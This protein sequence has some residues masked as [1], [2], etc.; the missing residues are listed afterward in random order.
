MVKE[1]YIIGIIK[2]LSKNRIEFEVTYNRPSYL[3]KRDTIHS[4]G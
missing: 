2:R 3:S 4:R 1:I